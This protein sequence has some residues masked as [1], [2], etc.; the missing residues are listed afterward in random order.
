MQE[1]GNGSVQ[2]S[3]ED[4]SGRV[5]EAVRLFTM[6]FNCCQSVF[7]AYADLF[8]MDREEALRLASPM[9][10][11]IGR[12]RE[13]CGTVSAMAMLSGLADGNSD[14]GDK[15][16]KT[17]VYQ[18]VRDMSDEFA[19]KNGSIICRELLGILGR[20]KSAAP[21]ARTDEYY[22]VRPCVKFVR[23]A[24]EIVEK[25]LPKKKTLQDRHLDIK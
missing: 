20:E 8:G 11:G 25:T 13:V 12:M 16:K 6:G 9:G 15:E 10:A 14:P 18:R 7:G 2:N 5:E 3:G 17:A 1:S 24:A 19:E 4:Q 21:S 22:A 23:C